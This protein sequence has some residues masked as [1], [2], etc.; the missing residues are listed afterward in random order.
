L[1]EIGKYNFKVFPNGIMSIPNFIQ[2][3]PAAVE[4]NHADRQTDRDDQPYMC[5]FHAHLI[6]RNFKE[7]NWMIVNNGG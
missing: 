3:H 2:I 5:S 4:L 7:R 6:K 1:K